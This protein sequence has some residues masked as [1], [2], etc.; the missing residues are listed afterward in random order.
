MSTVDRVSCIEN[1]RLKILLVLMS[2]YKEK[3]S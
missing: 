1:Y 3:K 2:T